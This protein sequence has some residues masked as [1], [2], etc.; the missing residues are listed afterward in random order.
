MLFT[1]II[2]LRLFSLLHFHFIV[3]QSAISFLY[4]AVTRYATRVYFAID[5]A[6]LII[7]DADD[8]APYEPYELSLSLPSSSL[9]LL[10]PSSFFLL[11][12]TADV[13]F[14]TDVAAVSLMR[15]VTPLLFHIYYCHA[16]ADTDATPR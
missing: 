5:A 13:H 7:D 15:H 9:L 8:A 4:Y 14:D 3:C 11:D 16:A 12:D 10:L 2:S 6:M 1:G